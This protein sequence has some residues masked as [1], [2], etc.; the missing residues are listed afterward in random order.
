MVARNKGQREVGGC[1]YRRVTGSYYGN[2]TAQYFDCGGECMKLHVIKLHITKC[3]C[4]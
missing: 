4:I 3:I 2:R 1:S